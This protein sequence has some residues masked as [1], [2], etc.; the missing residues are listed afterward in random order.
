MLETLGEKGNLVFQASDQ[1][2]EK[3]VSLDWMAVKE[4]L[5]LMATRVLQGSL[6]SQD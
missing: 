4:G 3:M 5:D 6:D 2:M 1:Q